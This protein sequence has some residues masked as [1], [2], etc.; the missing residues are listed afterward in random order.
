VIRIESI[1]GQ[2][3]VTVPK[4]VLVMTI[5]QFV[6]ALQCGK[7]WRWRQ[8]LTQRLTMDGADG[9]H[10]LT[11]APCWSDPCR[12]PNAT[13]ATRLHSIVKKG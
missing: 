4:T 9:P 8:A 5:Q 11:T 2:V 6:E 13:E 10:R 12:S 1:N 3:I 7:A